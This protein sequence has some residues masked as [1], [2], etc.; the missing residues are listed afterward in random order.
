MVIDARNQSDTIFHLVISIGGMAQSY[1]YVLSPTSAGAVP[2]LAQT[3][4][5]PFGQ[6]TYV[7]NAPLE[8]SEPI[9]GA[10]GR[11]IF[12]LMGNQSPYFPAENGFGVDEYALPE[13]ANISQMH[14]LQRHGSRY[15]P[16]AAPPAAWAPGIANATA[17][18]TVF[19]G[20]LSFLN[21]WSNILGEDMLVPLGPKELFESGV[22][23]YYNYGQ[24]YD[25][26]SKLVS[27]KNFLAGFFGLDWAEHANLIITIDPA[28]TGLFDC[29]R[30]FDGIFLAFEQADI[31]K[32]I[33][34][35]ERTAKLRKLTGNYNWT[36]A[37]SYYAQTLC[38]YE[39]VAVGYSDFCQ[40]FTYEEWEGFNYYMDI[41]AN[42][43]VGFVSPTGRAYGIAWVQ[44]FLARNFW[45]G[46][47]LEFG[48]DA[49][50]V[51]AMTAFGL[52]QFAEF[53][54]VTGP[55]AHHQFV[56]SKII[57]FAARLN[58]EII[59]APHKISARRSKTSAH[60]DDYIC[61]TGE[62]HY[63]YFILKQRTIP[64]HVSFE[65]CEYRDDGWCELPTFMNVQMESL[66]KA[67]Y[68]YACFGNWTMMGYGAY[69]DG[70][71]V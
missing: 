9:V 47:C 6:A 61:G 44:E 31:W 12:H 21:D 52:R 46:V 26:S 20:D 41:F 66:A 32:N 11:N 37:D 48:N 17:T 50:I 3:N 55:P 35:K 18:G 19:V 23:N 60:H 65:E 22:L 24:L 49:D 38:S 10:H 40:L 7:A 36:V 15:A 1:V 29:T 59:K 4:P 25:N 28:V 58:I 27:A 33:Y 39:T 70:R 57:P 2:F 67:D 53:L 30:Y 14:M 34:L 16:G 8:T 69:T 43:G 45:P 71:P 51:A 42:A 54:P 63:V 13:G 64:L 5:A 56:S 62:T 68:Q